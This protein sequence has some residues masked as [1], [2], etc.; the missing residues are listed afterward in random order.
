[1]SRFDKFLTV[2]ACTL[3]VGGVLAL[4]WVVAVQLTP[5]RMTATREITVGGVVH[6]G[7]NVV[8]SRGTTYWRDD[9]TGEA[10]SATGNVMVTP[11][12]RAADDK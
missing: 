1:M 9:T 4:A 11:I 8:T 2:V 5:L 12:E 10:C 6:R 7:Y 3:T